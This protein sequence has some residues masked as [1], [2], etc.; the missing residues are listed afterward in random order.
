MESIICYLNKGYMAHKDKILF[1]DEDKK[2]T[3]KE[4]Y[5]LVIKLVNLFL[6]SGLKKGQKVTLRTTRTIECS[7]IIIAL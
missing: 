5:F 3:Y 6:K 4:S 2:L 7:L 1:V